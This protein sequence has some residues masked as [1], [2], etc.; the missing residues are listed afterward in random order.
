MSQD[1][2]PARYC[3]GCSY[4]LDGL[5]ENRCPECGR[6]FEPDDPT[7]FSMSPRGARISLLY[8]TWPGRIAL[9]AAGLILLTIILDLGVDYGHRYETCARCGAESHVRH[10]VL[11]GLGGDYGRTIRE[12]AVSRFIQEQDSAR[13]VHQWQAFDLYG[14]TLFRRWAGTGRGLHRA[15]VTSNLEGACPSVTEFLRMRAREDPTFLRRFKSALQDDD[16]SSSA[17]LDQLV[18]EAADWSN[19]RAPFTNTRPS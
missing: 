15:I 12:G 4:V 3:L 2:G 11:L 13:C 7:T 9:V 18:Q 19:Q 17:F 5:P 10:L 6:P 14:G 16:D 8:K 1:I